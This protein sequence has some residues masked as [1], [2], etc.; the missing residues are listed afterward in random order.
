MHHTPNPDLDFAVVVS[1]DIVSR[2][3]DMVRA[4]S[5]AKAHGGDVRRTR[6]D[7]SFASEHKDAPIGE[8]LEKLITDRVQDL[9]AECL[10]KDDKQEISILGQLL[11]QTT[12]ELMIRADDPWEGVMAAQRVLIDLSKLIANRTAEL[13]EG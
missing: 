6:R 9:L 13:V 11:R 1:G 4:L 3:T 5:D 2:H 7:G 12:Y 10:T 8:Q